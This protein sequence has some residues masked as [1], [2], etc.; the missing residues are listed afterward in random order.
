MRWPLRPN[1][2]LLRITLRNG[3][4]ALR[5]STAPLAAEPHTCPFSWEE[6][7]QLA[8]LDDATLSAAAAWAS[9][10]ATT[11]PRGSAPRPALAGFGSPSAP[12]ASRGP[13]AGFYF[14][15]RQAPL[16]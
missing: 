9:S 14:P 2:S 6:W 3:S 5:L 8:E 13:L 16:P 11:W 12:A 1:S 7:R 4:Q 15:A 10:V